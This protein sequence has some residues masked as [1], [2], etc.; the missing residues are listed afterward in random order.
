MSRR[1]VSG[2]H[3]RVAVVTGTGQVQRHIPAEAARVLVAAGAASP[4]PTQGRIREVVLT[5]PASTHAHRTGPASAP[6]VGGVK[7]TRWLHLDNA[8]VL[9]HHP[10]CLY[11][12]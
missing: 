1:G 7:F 9:E 10:R 4:A 2:W 5:M 12:L 3:P 11:V 6:A 8:R